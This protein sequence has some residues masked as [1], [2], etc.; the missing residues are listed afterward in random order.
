MISKLCQPSNEE[1]KLFKKG[2]SREGTIEFIEQRFKMKNLG[3]IG[4]L[5]SFTYQ[6]NDKAE[7]GFKLRLLYDNKEKVE[8]LI[9]DSTKDK[10]KL[11]S[12]ILM[13][14][15]TYNEEQEEKNYKETKKI[16][17]KAF[18]KI[19]KNARN[20]IKK[21]ETEIETLEYQ[22]TVI[23]S[24][25]KNITKW[26]NELDENLKFNLKQLQTRL[27]NEWNSIFELKDILKKI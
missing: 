11:E 5:K 9:K 6:N 8:Q 12:M 14:N 27:D 17:D 23:E 20:L 25:S 16:L 18:R 10:K 1:R 2:Y 19:N 3:S 24:R 15:F 4:F 7:L 26:S 21:Y 22:Y 13:C